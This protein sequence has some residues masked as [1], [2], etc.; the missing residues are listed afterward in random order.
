MRLCF[1]VL[2]LRLTALLPAQVIPLTGAQLYLPPSLAPRGEAVDVVVHF[3]GAHRYAQRSFLELARNA[4]LL[5]VHLDGLSSVYTKAYAEPD[6][7][8]QQLDEALAAVKQRLP[9]REP[10]EG[11]LVLTGFSA[12]YAAV[13]AVLKSEVG[14]RV[15]AVVLGDGLHAGW[16][17][18]QQVDPVAM[19]GFVEFAK[20]A[21]RGEK[22]MKL[23]HSSIV[24]EGYAST[25]DCTDFLIDALGE[26]RV[27][28]AGTNALGMRRS[29]RCEVGGFLVEGFEGEQARDHVLHFRYLW[30]MLEQVTFGAGAVRPE[31]PLADSFPKGGRELPWWLERSAPARVQA[32]EPNAPGGDGH[33]LVVVDPAGGRDAVSIAGLATEDLF[34]EA[35]LWCE[36]RAELAGDG[37]ERIGVFLRGDPSGENGYALT[38]DSADGRLRC[39][40][41]VGGEAV[42]LGKAPARTGSAWRSLRIEALGKGLRFLV[43][44]EAVLETRDATH[45]RGTCGIL[46]R[47]SFATDSH[48]RGARADRFAA[49]PVRPM[50]PR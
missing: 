41:I 22:V 13:R 30:R 32:F 11:R 31:L 25:T 50:P 42:E 45:A 6:R 18:G 34:V 47:E 40:R 24:P 33:V 26:K 35:V 16:V 48:A 38:W 15:D 27:A 4:V 20:L 23:S 28:A 2:A 5:S 3:H 21:A 44:G 9:E 8:Q 37:G 17:D 1:L 12:G 29:S 39:E 14:K 46:W 10:R 43:D 19:Q 7:L 36:Q 49:G